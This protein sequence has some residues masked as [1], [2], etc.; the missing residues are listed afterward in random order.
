MHYNNVRY[1]QSGGSNYDNS[2]GSSAWETKLGTITCND[3]KNFKKYILMN[4]SICLLSASVVVVCAYFLNKYFHN[5]SKGPAYLVPRV[6]V[7]L[8]EE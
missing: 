1:I 7:S 4:I 3:T 2:L 5:A 6:H 8:D